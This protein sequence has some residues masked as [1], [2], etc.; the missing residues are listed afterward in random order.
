MAISSDSYI[1]LS[2]A[3]LPSL[4]K[5][6]DCN[7]LKMLGYTYKPI[8]INKY[9]HKFY[10]LS[11]THHTHH[12]VPILI[13]RVSIFNIISLN[14]YYTSFVNLIFSTFFSMSTILYW[15]FIYHF[16]IVLLMV[17]YECSIFCLICLVSIVFIRIL[18]GSGFCFD[19]FCYAN[20][21]CCEI[22]K[23]LVR[24]NG[25]LSFIYFFICFHCFSLYWLP[26]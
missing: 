24:L 4:T 9:K 21:F 19:G 10:P 25:L 20:G 6:K 16:H 2:A 7:H 17:F 12:H 1:L 23:K 5:F 18:L 26:F 22:R 11:P 13:K 14:I 15:S 8:L 3:R